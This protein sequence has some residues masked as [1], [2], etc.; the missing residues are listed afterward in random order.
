MCTKGPQR[1]KLV[2]TALPICCLGCATCFKMRGGQ[3]NPGTKKLARPT[4]K[5]RNLFEQA[6]LFVR[7]GHFVPYSFRA[8]LC[9]EQQSEKLPKPVSIMIRGCCCQTRPRR[10]LKKV[11]C[12][13]WKYLPYKLM[14]NKYFLTYNNEVRLGFKIDYV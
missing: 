10:K 11:R 1:V 7:R 2:N 12:V 3:W 9:Y 4:P 8:V 13:N 14:L 6:D 5:V